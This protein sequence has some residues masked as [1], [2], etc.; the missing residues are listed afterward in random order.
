MMSENGIDA[1]ISRLSLEQKVS[2][3]SGA[4][5]WRTHSLPEQGI[6]SFKVSKKTKHLP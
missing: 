4:S 1:I 2:L 5:M 3:L 6:R